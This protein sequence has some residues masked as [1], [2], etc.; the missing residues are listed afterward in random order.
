MNT[1]GGSKYRY[2]IQKGVLYR[3]ES[4]SKS[5]DRPQT[6]GNKLLCHQCTGTG[7]MSLAHESIVGGH[8]AAKKTIDRI[9]TSFH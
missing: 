5:E 9:I 3:E 8:L 1:K 7:V 4:L 2:I 6:S